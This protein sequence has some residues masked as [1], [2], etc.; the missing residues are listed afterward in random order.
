[1]LISAAM[2]IAPNVARTMRR[3]DFIRLV[4]GP[5][6]LWLFAAQAAGRP[7][8]GFLGPSSSSAFSPYVGAFHQGLREG[9]FIE[10]ET[11]EIE[12][13]WA[14]DHLDRCGLGKPSDTSSRDSWRN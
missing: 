11:I 13:R 14:N 6:A 8:I 2:M 10:G 12:Y 1:M 5:P 4:G 9:G 7:L 3:R